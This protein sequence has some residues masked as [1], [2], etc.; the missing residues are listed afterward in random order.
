[1]TK[2]RV[3]LI[4]SALAFGLA[5][6]S[7]PAMAD[8]P[9]DQTDQQIGSCAPASFDST[10]PQSWVR[11]SGDTLD[12]SGQ[13]MIPNGAGMRQDFDDLKASP[14]GGSSNEVNTGDKPQ[15][16]LASTAIDGEGKKK[17]LFRALAL[18]STSTSSSTPTNHTTNATGEAK[19]PDIAPSFDFALAA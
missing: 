18:H 19:H 6:A 17:S 8:D 3:L 16:Y 9:G 11:L 4:A 7:P 2:G 1:M 12:K 5:T 14:G 13:L 10:S 15:V